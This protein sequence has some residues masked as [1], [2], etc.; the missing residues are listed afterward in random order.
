MDIENINVAWDNFI[1]NDRSTDDNIF[2]KEENSVYV[3]NI[4][5]DN[6]EKKSKSIKV[7]KC[8]ELHISTK[9]KIAHLNQNIDLDDIFWKLNVQKYFIPKEGIIKKQMKLNSISQ[10]QLDIITC[11]VEEEDRHVNQHIISHIEN[12][13]GRVKFKDIRKI[14]VGISKKDIESYRSKIKSA[15]YNCFVLIIR[16]KLNEVFKEIHVKVFNTGQLEIPGIQT[17]EMFEIVM[18]VLLRNLQPFVPK[19]IDYNRSKTETILY[20]S[21]FNCGFYINRDKFFNLLKYKYKIQAI[22]DPCSYPGIQCK[23]YYNDSDNDD[24][25]KEMNGIKTETTNRKISFMI[26]RTGSTLIVGKCDK[27]ILLFVYDFLRN[28]M[29]N[30]YNTIMQK[31]DEEDKKKKEK[32]R[33]I[34]KKILITKND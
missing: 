26:F 21:N 7:P 2:D 23:F 19:L 5:E 3:E 17:D 18:N 8:S 11:H 25:C 34:K 12:P 29:K 22:Y 33:R 24:T 15:F 10:E 31:M 20:N 1:T 28:V 13:D 32:K 14:N 4:I 30:E 27:Q 16:I 9:T 6:M